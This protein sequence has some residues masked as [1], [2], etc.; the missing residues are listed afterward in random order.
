MKNKQRGF[1]VPIL[2]ALIALM[3]VGGGVYVYNQNKIEMPV[4]MTNQVQNTNTQNNSIATSDWKIYLNNEGF[5]EFSYPKYATTS[6]AGSVISEIAV[7]L[8]KDRYASFTVTTSPNDSGLCKSNP[9]DYGLSNI[10]N[11]KVVENNIEED[12]NR[13]RH[14]SMTEKDSQEERYYIIKN[15]FCYMIVERMIYSDKIDSQVKSD[16]SQIFTTFKFTK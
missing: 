2:I 15:N 13:Y 14:L 12:G 1:I 16:L 6:F 3:A 4:D 8:T 5:Y 10:T 11:R 9:Y 7:F